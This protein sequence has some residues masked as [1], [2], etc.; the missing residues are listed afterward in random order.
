MLVKWQWINWTVNEIYLYWVVS[1]AELV[2]QRGIIQF[3]H[4]S[5]K[6]P[7]YLDGKLEYCEGGSGEEMEKFLNPGECL[8]WTP[9][10]IHHSTVYSRCE[11]GRD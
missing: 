7:Q 1:I 11:K 4:D 10:T 6:I 5:R 3:T 8:I 9:S 2:M